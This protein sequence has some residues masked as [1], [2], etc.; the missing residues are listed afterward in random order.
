MGGGI[1]LFSL[2]NDNFIDEIYLRLLDLTKFTGLTSIIGTFGKDTTTL[3][4]Q[5][6]NISIDLQYREDKITLGNLSTSKYIKISVGDGKD[7][8]DVS[9]AKLQLNQK[10]MNI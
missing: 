9:K 8:I 6:D 2:N 1:D 3:E 5:S 4:K 7:T 10:Q